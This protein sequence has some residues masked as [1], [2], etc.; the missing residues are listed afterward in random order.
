MKRFSDL[1]ERTGTGVFARLAEKKREA[2]A[3]GMTIYDLYVG[4][5]DFPCEKHITDAGIKAMSDPEN[6]KYTLL[7]SPGMIS[8]VVN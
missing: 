7:D 3:R 4:T 5:P 8:A 6:I 2:E 1:S